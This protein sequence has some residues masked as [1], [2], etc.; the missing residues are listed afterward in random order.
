MYNQYWMLFIFILVKFS[1][2]IC[3]YLPRLV[4]T[5]VYKY[6]PKFSVD[7]KKYLPK[8]SADRNKYLQ[9]FLC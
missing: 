5:S 4:L 6:L 8:F 1:V 2:E 3:K 7:R 9:H